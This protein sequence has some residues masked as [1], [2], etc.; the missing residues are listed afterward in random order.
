MTTLT[1]CA[2]HTP[3]GEAISEVSNFFGAEQYTFCEGCENNIYR[4]TIDGENDRLPR[5]SG[6][7]LA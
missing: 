7:V 6:W 3:H 5:W 1:K 2:K 4:F